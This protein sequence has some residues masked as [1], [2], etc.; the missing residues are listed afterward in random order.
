MLEKVRNSMQSGFTYVL[1]AGL[2]VIFM[3]FFGM[4]SRGCSGGANVRQNMFLANVGN[5]DVY[6]TDVDG[7]VYGLTSA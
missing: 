3:F 5:D 6:T 1:V 2:T 7:T 4:P